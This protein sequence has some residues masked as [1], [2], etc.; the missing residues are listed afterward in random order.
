MIAKAILQGMESGSHFFGD[1][2][3]VPL[4]I[5]YNELGESIREQLQEREIP[6]MGDRPLLFQYEIFG[7]YL[8]RRVR[9]NDFYNA[10]VELMLN[11]W[12]INYGRKLFVGFGFGDWG[13]RMPTLAQRR[14]IF[15][16]VGGS[17]KFVPIETGL[18]LRTAR[19]L[20]FAS[21]C[22]IRICAQWDKL[23]D[24]LVFGAYFSEN[25]TKR[26]N[27]TI[28]KLE[29]F[30]DHQH[31]QTAHQKDCLRVLVRLARLAE[32]LRNWRDHDLHQF[33]ETVFGVLEKTGTDHSLGSLWD[34]VVEEHNRVREATMA[35]VGMIVLGPE[36]TSL[37]HAAKLPPPVRYVAFDDPDIVNEHSQLVETVKRKVELQRALQEADSPAQKVHCRREILAADLE[38]KRALQGLY[39]LPEAKAES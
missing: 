35:M 33:S 13:K 38:I 24:N 11:E 34:T 16:S 39:G 2:V 5:S 4:G 31:L 37:Y 32:G 27:S 18:N 21:E 1:D 17:D 28:N 8:P 30:E 23:I 26:F 9:I 7:K 20:W 29:T 3:P 19:G 22:I 12:R 36:T 14:Q 15:Q 10:F 6:I 25:P